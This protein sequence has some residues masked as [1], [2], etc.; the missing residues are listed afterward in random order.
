M[1]SEAL[2]ITGHKNYSDGSNHGFAATIGGSVGSFSHNLLVN[3]YGR[4]WSMGGGLDGAGNAAGEL[5]MFNNVCYNWGRRTTDGG[6]L[7]MQFVNNYYKMGEA[8]TIKVLF[9]A[10]NEDFS[11]RSQ[12]AYV[13]GN[14]RENNNHTLTYD[15]KGDTYN[16]SGPEPELT[17]YDEP[18][19]PSCATIHSA[20]DAMKIV[21]SYA[22][23]TMPVRD[24]QHLR[25]IEETLKGTYTYIGSRSK[26]K[27]E[28]DHEDDAGGWETYSEEYRGADWDTDQDGMPDWWEAVIG[29]NPAVANHN[30][31]PNDDGWTLLEDYLEFMAHPYMIIKTGEQ[32]T[33]DVKPYFAGFYGQNGN[34]VTPSF[35]IDA[36]SGLFTASV[37]G[38]VVT[39]QAGQTSGVDYI[40]VVV[41]DGET[42]WS[43][44]IGIAITDGT[45]GIFNVCRDSVATD[46]GAS[47]YDLQ[48]RKVEQPS[49][50]IY[51][52]NGKMVVIP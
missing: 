38:S 40:Q 37:A 28:I 25:N 34:S 13:S 19:F 4:N 10:Q 43:Q 48:G 2:G 47:Y 27:G 3:C 26:I 36:P 32:Q 15:K 41:N 12:F 33:L 50:G 30:D 52:Q 42:T 44:R 14:I 20:K 21:T 17:W 49:K 16:A 11:H 24:D 29:S 31:D 22:G 1:I 18:F 23:A 35:S 9:T 39:A 7:H 8:S 51:I 46:Q 5:D 6:A 45:T